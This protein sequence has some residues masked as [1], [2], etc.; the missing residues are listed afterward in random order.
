MTQIGQ[1][2]L[3]LALLLAIYFVL[4]VIVGAR[5]GLPEL[6]TSGRWA[7]VVVFGLTTVAAAALWYAFLTHD[8]QVS[9]VYGYSDR[10]MSTFYLVGAF[11]GGQEG[12]LLLWTLVLSAFAVVVVYQTRNRN[13]EM[14]PYVVAVMGVILVSF[15]LIVNFLSSPFERFDA[16]PP[17][18]NGLNPLL[19]NVG[20]Y[21]HPLTLYI[22][23]VGFSVP[24][25]FCLAALITGRLDDQ[26]IKSTRRWTLFAWLFLSLGNL[27]GAQWAYTEL[28]WGG[29]WGWDPVESASFMP[30][31]VGT[32][33]LHSVMIQQRRGMLKVWNIALIVT[34]FTLT[35]FGTFL[36]RSGVISSVHSFGQSNMGPLFIAL[37]ALIVVVSAWLT[38]Y[39]LPQLKGENE[40]DS[41]LSR[42]SSFLFNNLILVGAAFAV[43]LGTV[44]PL[45]SEAVRGVKVTVGPP[46][47]KSVTAPIFLGLIALMGICPL[48]GWRRASKDNIIRNFLYP[49]SIALAVTLGLFI[50]GIREGYALIAFSLTIFV[51]STILLE[52]YRGTR[53][54]HR[55]NGQNYLAA[56]GGMVW[57]NKPRYGGYIVHLG[58]ILMAVGIIASQAYDKEV[59]FTLSPGESGKINNYTL[60]YQGMDY[61][62]TEKREVITATLDVYNGGQQKVATVT[63]AKTFHQNHENPVTE[64]AIRTTPVEDLYIILEGWEQQKAAFKFIVN[65]MV[66]WIWI[67]GLVLIAGTIVAFW[68]DARERKHELARLA[69]AGSYVEEDKYES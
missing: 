67:G 61:F 10:A 39:R 29:Y 15:L 45:V 32:A 36:T 19:E 41:F 12:S 11:W 22:G 20:M 60:V 38:L 57:H 7:V 27:F 64:V 35:I 37:M 21:F 2:A 54:K 23:Y 1:I 18:G 16:V 3:I 30:W 26:W 65:P 55:N 66:L 58:V 52:I 44:F 40:L 4:A 51:A 69:R 42:E 48:I 31:L 9:Y 62:P 25:A 68:P 47:F 5:R 34:T 14:A 13:R 33:Y 53:A 46:F 43:F 17:D 28:G 24:F 59:E 56:L 50:A 8:F 49:F 6:A 63:P